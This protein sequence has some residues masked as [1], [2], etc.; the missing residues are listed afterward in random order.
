MNIGEYEVLRVK[1]EL[2]DF[3]KIVRE[4]WQ[5]C[6]RL[7]GKGLYSEQRIYT[8]CQK[9]NHYFFT[10]LKQN[11]V[12]GMF[13]CFADRAGSISLAEGMDDLQED[14]R[15]GV[16]QSIALEKELRRKGVAEAMLNYATGLLFHKEKV[17]MI[18]IPAWVQGTEIPARNHLEKCGY[19]FWKMQKRPWSSYENLICP[20]CGQSPC[21]CDGAV[22]IKEENDNE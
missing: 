18:L 11:Q 21:I 9:E 20:V 2:P 3:R 15:I 4:V 16:A 1:P 7:L 17:K 8:I 12:E 13:Y 10:I 14:T 22:Y 6:E 5:I 19:R